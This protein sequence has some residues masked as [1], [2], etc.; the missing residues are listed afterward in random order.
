YETIDTWQQHSLVNGAGFEMGAAYAFAPMSWLE[1]GVGLN[2]T[3]SSKRQHT[4]F[5]SYVGSILV[6]SNLD[7]YATW[8]AVGAFEPV[9]RLFPLG[10]TVVQPYA[11]AGGLL[12]FFDRYRDLASTDGTLTYVGRPG[13]TS[14]GPM[15]GT[16]LRINTSTRSFL[17]L[18]VP[19]VWLLTPEHTESGGEL[20][21]GHLDAPYASGQL[22]VFRL[23][24]GLKL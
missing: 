8:A 15:V 17:G 24:V 2:L 14:G 10:D 21:T 5:E 11:L 13:S 20:V 1:V 22:V 16:G 12:R 7:T 19:W 9:A 6:D 4:G 18:E 23:D 3:F